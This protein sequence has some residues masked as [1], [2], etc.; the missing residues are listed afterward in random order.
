MS[1]PAVRDDARRA[2]WGREV[3]ARLESLRLFPVREAAIVD[4]LTDH[5]EEHWRE[6]VA[7]GVTSDEATRL[8][9]A[10]FRGGNLLARYMSSLRQSNTSQQAAPGATTG[11]LFTDIW[12]DLRYAVR[13]F[14]RQPGFA[15]AAV[16]TLALGIGANSAIFSV[17]HAVLMES[18]PFSA[19]ERLYRVRM[20]YPDGSAYTTLS[21]P[22]FMSVREQ[23]RV[24]EQ[25]EAYTSGRVTM[26]GGGEPQEVSAA[27]ISDGLFGMLGMRIVAGR[28]FLTE[29]HAPGRNR[30]AVVDHGFWRRAFGGDAS[31]IGRSLVIGGIPYSVVGVLAQGAR[32]PDDVPGARVASDADVYLPIEYSEAFSATATEQRSSRYLAVLARAR[33]GTTSALIDDDL[34]R[35]ASDVQATLP[36]TSESL[37]MNAITARELIVG[38]V[39]KPL[40]MLLGAVGFVLLVACANVASLMLARASARR[41]ELSVRVALGAGRGRLLRQLFTEAVV[42]ALVGGVIGL[43]LAHIGTQAL[44]AAQPADIPRLE[45]IGL[46]RSVLLFTFAI[47]LVASLAFGVLPAVQAMGHVTHGLRAGG[48]G[49]GAD[50]QSRRVRSGLVVAEIALAV[51]LLTG[52]GLLLRSLVALTRVSPGFVAEDTVAFRVALYGRDYDPA[53]VRARV[54]EIEAGLRALPGVTSVSTTSLLPL[55][56]PGPRLSFG[57]AGAPLP[58][59]RVNR[60][61]GVAS[62]APNYFRTIG[63]T[64]VLGRDLTDRDHAEAPPVAVINQAA[65]RRWFAGVD[66]IGKHVHMSGLREVVGVVAD[67]L[68]GDPKQEP[69]PQ[70]FV[71]SAQRMVRSFWFVIR[72][73]GSSLAL[74]PSVR[75]VV[76]RLDADLAISELTTLDQLRAGS[77]ARPRF[78]AALLALFAMVALALAV[79]GIFGVMSYAVAERTREIGIRM[80]LGARSADVVRMIVGR[81]LTLAMIGVSIGLVAA[82]AVGRVIQNQLFGVELVDPATLAIVVLILLASAAAASYV[83]ARRAS[84]LDPAMTLR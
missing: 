6:L 66:P 39:R 48:R 71:P 78:Y 68:Q 15:I 4:E 67:V 43:V 32:L 13:S 3:R 75:S 80:A 63:A 56:G 14:A 54:S 44:V 70:L 74:A 45:A 52:A 47:A 79:T 50:R 69:A 20:V 24:F 36:P 21:A 46:D 37:S 23:S 38:D 72:A 22:D 83:P 49:G 65:V 33:A 18:L 29:E 60:E 62:V 27:S 81:T 17:V 58:S 28:G 16:L 19:A 41:E 8:T 35:V 40:L 7:G 73:P 55:S 1:D 59:A 42:L 12:R 9:L 84:N 34:R 57:V 61:I 25:V 76:H 30:V 10:Q 64:L 11:H 51:M 26:L 5:L 31:A 77:V 53:T 2:G 82:F